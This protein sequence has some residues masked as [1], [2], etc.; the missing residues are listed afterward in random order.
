MHRSVARTGSI[1][2]GC[3][4]FSIGS[5][6][7]STKS[8]VAKLLGD[9]RDALA[10][11]DISW[12][13]IGAQAA[14]VHGANRLTADV[15]VTLD[16]RKTPV[17]RLLKALASQ[18]F[19]PQIPDPKFIEL[20]RVIPVL[21]VNTS[22]PVDLVLAG[23][24][25][26]EQFFERAVAIRVGSRNILFAAPEDLIV[27]KVL[28]S[29]P[30]DL[31]DVESIL[32]ARRDALDISLIRKTLKTAELLLD[33]SDLLPAFERLLGSTRSRKGPKVHELSKQTKRTVSAKRPGVSLPR[34]SR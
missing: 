21:H 27:M 26:E 33:Q 11:L 10:S 17:A 16:L 15:D 19:K 12:F 25:L 22:I 32:A 7:P 24:G 4:C 2:L 8:P 5:L 9:L 18:G 13:V 6:M 28:S 14:I 23:P 1:T 29:R 20:T 30:K 3:G 34:R 31:Q